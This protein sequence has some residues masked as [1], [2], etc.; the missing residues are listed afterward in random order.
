M[1]LVAS[2]VWLLAHRSVLGPPLRDED[3][4]DIHDEDDQRNNAVADDGAVRH[5]LA[6]HWACLH[7]SE[8]SIHNTCQD[9]N[10]TKPLMDGAKY[11]SASSSMVVQML[12]D[13]ESRLKE[14]QASED[15]VPNNLVVTTKQ[16]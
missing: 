12:V 5:I 9:H 8:T 1:H 15:D 10:S 11:T 4:S 3:H 16:V 13:P 2:I 14:D 7:E 6:A